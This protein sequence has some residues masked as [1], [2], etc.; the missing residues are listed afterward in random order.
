MTAKPDAYGIYANTKLWDMVA[1]FGEDAAGMAE[2]RAAELREEH[3]DAQVVVKKLFSL[4]EDTAPTDD[5]LDKLSRLMSQAIWR[6]SHG[7]SW[8]CEAHAAWDLGARPTNADNLPPS[9][10]P[11]G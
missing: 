9:I 10:L 1:N 7:Q 3:P 5:D 11:K 2:R 8:R 6:Y 4:A